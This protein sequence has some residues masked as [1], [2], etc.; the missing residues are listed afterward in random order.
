MYK[1]SAECLEYIAE[2]ED[3]SNNPPI[4]D[5]SF[6]FLVDAASAEVDFY[7]IFD[8]YGLHFPTKVYFGARYGFTQMIDEAKWSS[9]WKSNNKWSMEFRVCGLNKKKKGVHLSACGQAGYSEK[10]SNEELRNFSSYFE[11]T[12]EFSLGRRMPSDSGLQEW[13]QQVTE[14]PM[15]FRYDLKSLCEHPV[16]S[17]KKEEC[18]RYR[19]SYCVKHL[20]Y[21][22]RGLSCDRAQQQECTWDMDCLPRHRCTME[23]R[24]LPYPSC[25]VAFYPDPNS[26]GDPRTFGPVYYTDGPGGHNGGVIFDATGRVD[27]VKVSEGCDQ[28]ILMDN[29]R[30]GCLEV[31]GD[32]MLLGARTQQY[33]VN[34]LPKDLQNDIC[35]VKL[36]AR[37]E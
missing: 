8:M 20:V 26:G 16:F 17:S 29:D 3:L 18:S 7:T 9:L 4:S 36:L 27:S 12:K 14:E 34:N 21:T 1:T 2:I 32:N 31:R 13:S 5:E 6:L 37:K 35:K 19:E 11:Q 24:C 30:G 33:E 22:H 15:P 23:G 28:V 25:T 10:N